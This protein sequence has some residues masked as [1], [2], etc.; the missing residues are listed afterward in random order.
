MSTASVMTDVLN[1]MQL[2]A[3][4]SPTVSALRKNYIRDDLVSLVGEKPGRIDADHN[5]V[6]VSR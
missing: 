6:K 5:R 4:F 3:P 1:F 2:R